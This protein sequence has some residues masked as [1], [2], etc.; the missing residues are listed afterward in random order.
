[1]SARARR[2]SREDGTRAALAAELRRDCEQVA[3]CLTRLRA[4]PDAELEREWQGCRAQA[5]SLRERISAAAAALRGARQERDGAWKDDLAASQ[6]LLRQLAA[7]CGQMATRASA[8]RTEVGRR[9]CDLQRGSRALRSY[10][11]AAKR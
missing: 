1:M 10:G 4:V 8:E 5:A 11:Q 7:A 9:L 6:D 2:A 3:Q